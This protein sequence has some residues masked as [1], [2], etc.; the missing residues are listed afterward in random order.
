MLFGYLSNLHY[1][2]IFTVIF[3]IISKILYPESSLST[4]DIITSPLFLINIL[5]CI[6]YLY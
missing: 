2:N 6:V 4:L 3:N 5:V 1:Y